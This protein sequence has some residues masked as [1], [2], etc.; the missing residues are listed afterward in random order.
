M[1]F[2]EHLEELRRRVLIGLVSL[3]AFTL[4]AYALCSFRLLAL[5]RV[6]FDAATGGTVRL[7][8]LSPVEIILVRIKLAVVAGLVGASPVLIY[9][10]LAFIVPGLKPEERR[11]L[12]PALAGGLLLF[13]AGV[14]L[15][16]FTVLPIFFD[17]MVVMNADADTAVT[18]SVK[19]VMHTALMLLLAFGIAFELPLLI[20]FLTQIGVVTPRTLASRRKYAL[21][22]ILVAAAVITPPDVVTMLVLGGPLYLLYEL[23]I[24]LAGVSYKR[25][26]RRVQG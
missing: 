19:S 2:S 26:L 5:L 6:P 12:K 14:L 7:A 16:Y 1:T 25:R 10:A 3:A 21:V 23:S 17:L 24:V 4:A 20:V 8:T 15:C 9:H 18:W 11:Y 22:A 13:I